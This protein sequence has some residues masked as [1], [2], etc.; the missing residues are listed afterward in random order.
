MHLLKEP[1]FHVNVNNF[2]VYAEETFAQIGQR[3][4][5]KG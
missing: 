1:A 5:E 4:P 2:L 3:L